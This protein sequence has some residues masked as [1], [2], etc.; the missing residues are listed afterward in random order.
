ML[1]WHGNRKILHGCVPLRL[2]SLQTAHRKPGALFLVPVMPRGKFT[3]DYPRPAV[4]VDIVIVT[5]DR[6][7]RVLLIQRKHDPFAGAWAEADAASAREAAM[8]SVMRI[9]CMVGS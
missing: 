5:R 4:T 3:Y 8:A 7:R 1:M 6:A 2:K 9:E